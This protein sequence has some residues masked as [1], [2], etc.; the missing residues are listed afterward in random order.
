MKRASLLAA[1][2]VV[3]VA[4]GF[5]LAHAWRNRSGPVTSDITLTQRE[6]PEPYRMQNEDSGVTLNLRWVDTHGPFYFPDRSPWLDQGM[7]REL[8]FDTSV[9]PSDATASEFYQRQRARRVFVALEYDG[10]GWNRWMDAAERQVPAGVPVTTTG[11]N[12]KETS[13]RLVAIDASRD[14]AKL[15]ARHPE[16]S[17]VLIVPAVVRISTRTGDSKRPAELYG[18]IQQIPSS[19]HVPLPFRDAFRRLPGDRSNA[20]YRVHLQYGALFEPWIAG[21]DIL[22]PATP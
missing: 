8:G 13:T 14:A 9:A 6:L 4:N 7:L 1:V 16:K 19:I 22:P 15:R 12:L 11:S 10:P 18:S 21:V 17:S 2:A 3:L 20:K 5:A